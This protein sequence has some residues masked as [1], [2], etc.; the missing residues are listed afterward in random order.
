[1]SDLTAVVGLTFSLARSDRA[2][3]T[4]SFDVTV[5]NTASHPLLLPVILQLTPQQHFDGEPLGAQGRAADGSWLI[6][7]SSSLPPGGLLQP[8]QTTTGKTITALTPGRRPLAFDSSVTGFLGA[9]SA[10]VFLSYPVSSATV[11][12]AY[13]YQPVGFDKDG[14]GLTYVLVHAPI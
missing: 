14:D 6:D 9:N 2:S 10:P 12:A 13:S 1:I 5:T 11:G 4:V 3:G 7:L 8:G